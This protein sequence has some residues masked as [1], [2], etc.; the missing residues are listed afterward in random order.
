[1]LSQLPSNCELILVDDGSEDATCEILETWRKAYNNLTIL[2]REHKGASAARNAGLLAAKGEYVSF[3]DCDDCLKEGFL[4]KSL[5]L[6]ESGADLYIFGIERLLL[7]GNRELWTVNSNV[8]PEVSDFADDYIRVRKLLVYSNCNKFYRRSVIEKQGVRFDEASVFGEDRLFNYNFLKGCK[9]VISSHFIML[10]YIQ[11]STQSMSSR[12]ISG[13]FDNIIR[14][15]KAKMDCFL[16]LSKGTTEEEKREF[17]SYDISREVELTI[18]R[19]EE[20]PEEK[21]ENLPKVNQLI[22]GGPYNQDTPV[23]ILIVLGSGNCE[24]RVKKALEIGQKNPGM[25]YI[26]SGGNPHLSGTKTEAEFMA[27]YL[28]THGVPKKDIF[29]EN[30]AQFTRQNLEFS[31]GIVKR[32]RGF[33]ESKRNIGIVTGGFHVRRTQMIA[34]NIRAFSGESLCYFPAYGPHTGL[35]NWYKDCYG[36]PIVLAELRKIVSRFEYSF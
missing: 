10:E 8:Y 28:K 20:H 25:R 34:E 36:K 22:F 18:N 14:L 17:R 4:E 6:T 30:R 31:A 35:D 12:H 7:S 27:E 5:P 32:L 2:K 13:Y 19:F 24:Y 29:L 15:H 1:M 23:D 9:T 21:E 11:R 26:V 3:I 33:T 16:S